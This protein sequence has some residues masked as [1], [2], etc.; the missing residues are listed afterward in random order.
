[1]KAEYFIA[2]SIYR[3]FFLGSLLMKMIIIFMVIAI[4]MFTDRRWIIALIK[5]PRGLG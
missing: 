1:M 2:R 5:K 3:I 4:Q